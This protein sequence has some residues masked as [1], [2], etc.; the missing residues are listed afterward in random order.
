[1]TIIGK[2]SVTGNSSNNNFAIVKNNQS[3]LKGLIWM[4]A[5]AGLTTGALVLTAATVAVVAGAIVGS[6]ATGPV[7]AIIIAGTAIAVDY[8]AI[9]FTGNCFSN[10]IHHFGNEY[11]II[12]EK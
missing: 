5:G 3:N 7:P 2:F 9:K 11:Q 4:S 1:M 12:R 6:A 10:A 8:M